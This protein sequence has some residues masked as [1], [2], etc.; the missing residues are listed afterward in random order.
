[1]KASE[2]CSVE[3]AVLGGM[4]L[5]PHWPAE[6]L[7]LE[8]EYF[9]DQLDA[10]IFQ[11]MCEL[12]AAGKHVD[13]PAVC[14][15]LRLW[16]VNGQ[17]AYVL[18]LAENC[19]T[20]INL[21]HWA[22]MLGDEGRKR[23]QKRRLG[24]VLRQAQSDPDM[25]IAEATRHAIDSVESEKSF[26]GLT[27]LSGI[28]GAAIKEIQKT[29]EDPNYGR[30][31][32]TG[33]K[34]LDAA[35]KLLGGEMTI[36]AGRP[37][38]GKTSLACNIAAYNAKIPANDDR[39][40]YRPVAFFSLEMTKTILIKRMLTYV[41]KI[42]V[43]N[44]RDSDWPRFANNA[45]S[46]KD[47]N[48]YLDDR[49]GLGVEDIRAA[50]FRI[51][52]PKIVIIDYLQKMKLGKEERQDLRLATITRRLTDIAKE[53]SCHVILLCQLNRACE[54]RKPPKP[55]MSDLRDSGAIEQDANNIIFPY[56]PAYY[57]EEVDER[58]A[59]MIIAKQREGR[60]CDVQ[61]A[62]NGETTSFEDWYR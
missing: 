24:D 14:S 17:A 46:L 3:G 55:M 4:L 53:F 20:T 23:E 54:Q 22:K 6:V 43:N 10:Q 25:D 57:G 32:A 39:R 30:I 16:G 47:L 34:E 1:M 37:G 51:P 19:P 42:R 7:A 61:V 29:M 49:P 27:P 45:G 62:W 12:G 11:A 41:A 58:L 40:N 33:L 44:P 59:E 31:A 36:I 21:G 52:S 50:L 13:E 5:E 2:P 60:T 18:D 38:M 9:T 15:K 28:V 26:D 35:V 48:L 8:P 56:R